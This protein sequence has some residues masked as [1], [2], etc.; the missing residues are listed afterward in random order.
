LPHQSDPRTDF[1]AAAV[2]K[3]DP[4]KITDLIEQLERDL[5]ETQKRRKALPSSGKRLAAYT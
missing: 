5:A 1:A 2:D 4:Q 3:R